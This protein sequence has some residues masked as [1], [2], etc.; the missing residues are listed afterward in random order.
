MSHALRWEN[1]GMAVSALERRPATWAEYEALGEDVRA[2]YID[3]SI[4]MT[5]SPSQR[6]QITSSR[7]W[8]AL[9]AVLP[10]QYRAVQAWAWKSGQDE[11]I[12]DV[13]VYPANDEQTRFTGT[14]VLC[15]EVLSSNRANDY[16]TKVAKYAEAGLDHYW[17]V[18]PESGV[19]D[20]LVRDGE[21]YR[22]DTQVVLSAAQEVTF[23]ISSVHIDLAALL[24]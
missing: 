2:E 23:G 11:F 20:V 16:V 7:L 8:A 10:P 5:P 14:P 3:A 4:V 6:H 21:H 9:E 17:I 18:D 19:L 22:L 13:M 1:D 15:I 12:P 24:A